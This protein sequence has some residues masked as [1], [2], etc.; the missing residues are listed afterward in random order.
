[1]NRS[2]FPGNLSEGSVL[3][4]ELEDFYHAAR[5][6]SKVAWLERIVV[7]AHTAS[8]LL[9]L[10]SRSYFDFFRSTTHSQCESP[11]GMLLTSLNVKFWFKA[12]AGPSPHL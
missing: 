8:L 7:L 10:P 11:L 2:P 4:F 5:Q 9:I 12:S 6:Q 3:F 1:V